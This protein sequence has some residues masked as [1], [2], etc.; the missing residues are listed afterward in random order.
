MQHQKL[1][2]VPEFKARIF[3]GKSSNADAS[4]QE[5]DDPQLVR[6]TAELA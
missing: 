1:A 6:R 5:P 3:A 2:P 4:T